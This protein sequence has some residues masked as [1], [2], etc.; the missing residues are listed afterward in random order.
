MKEIEFHRCM[1]IMA[2]MY[3]N[4]RVEGSKIHPDGEF[5][6]RMPRLLEAIAL[7]AIRVYVD[8]QTI[9]VLKHTAQT[10]GIKHDFDFHRYLRS[11]YDISRACKDCQERADKHPAGSS[12]AAGP[13]YGRSSNLHESLEYVLQLY[14]HGT[15]RHWLTCD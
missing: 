13:V 11:V 12:E 7:G 14:V 3:S 9:D 6:K 15:F 10:A 2:Q 4:I 8:P 1:G 5:A